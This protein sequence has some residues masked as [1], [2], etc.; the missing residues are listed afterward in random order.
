MRAE[1][2][3]MFRFE[4]EEYCWGNLLCASLLHVL[5]QGPQPQCLPYNISSCCSNSFGKVTQTKIQ[6]GLQSK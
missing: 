1:I 6:L 5:K 4:P 2:L 3:N